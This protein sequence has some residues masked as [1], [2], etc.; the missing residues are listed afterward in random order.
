MGWDDFEE[1]ECGRDW[2]DPEEYSSCYECYLERRA[3]YISCIWCGRWHSPRFNT[4]FQCRTESPERDNA[5]RDL[6]LDI[7]IRD[8][9]LCQN[10]GSA[11]QP[12][13]DHIEPCAKGGSAV[14][15]NLQVLCRECNKLKGA[16]YDW[17]WEQRRLRLMHL[18]FTFGWPLLDSEQRAQLVE[19]ADDYMYEYCDEFAWHAH[20][21]ELSGITTLPPQWA[22]DMADAEI[23]PTY[24]TLCGSEL[25]DPCPLDDL[26]R[27]CRLWRF[28][29][30]TPPERASIQQEVTP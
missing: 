19:D 26:C 28:A 23:P 1:C 4:C 2:Y 16:N 13:V 20:Y 10:C 14:P 15:W 27:E 30:K 11:D 24:C 8:G 7:L 9:F 6:R 5:G 25:L 18:Y 22:L 3:N 29:M 21:Q 12:Q 17:R